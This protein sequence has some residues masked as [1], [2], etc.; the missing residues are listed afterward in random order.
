MSY[1]AMKVISR[2]ICFIFKNKLRCLGVCKNKIKNDD[3]SRRFLAEGWSTEGCVTK[4]VER[5]VMDFGLLILHKTKGVS[6]HWTGL[7]N[8]NIF[9]RYN[10]ENGVMQ[11]ISVLI[12]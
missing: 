1:K 4:E 10:T 7:L 5:I 2:I 11:L 3:W 6:I 12:T 8:S 9:Y